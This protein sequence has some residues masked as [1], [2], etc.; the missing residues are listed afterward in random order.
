M[1]RV[2]VRVRIK[3]KVTGLSCE[4]AQGAAD[5]LPDASV[6]RVGEPREPEGRTRRV[7]RLLPLLVVGERLHDAQRVELHLLHLVVQQQLEHR[8]HAAAQQRRP[9]RPSSDEVL[10]RARRAQR[11]LL[12]AR[13]RHHGYECRHAARRGHLLR[14]RRRR[15]RREHQ[16]RRVLG[17][18]VHALRL[19]HLNQPAEAVR[20][21]DGLPRHRHAR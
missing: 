20:I 10:E 8:C 2:R 5:C 7:D 1:G 19:G 17:P 13:A 18:L 12:L 11:Q 9:R 15:E 14:V 21:D 4:R 16:R 6:A 3:V